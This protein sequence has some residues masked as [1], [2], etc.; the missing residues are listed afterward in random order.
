LPTSPAKTDVLVRLARGED[1]DGWLPLW[2]G[3][4]AFYGREGP[5]ALPD[6]VTADRWATFLAP[7]TAMWSLVACRGDRLVGLANYLFHPS[8]TDLAPSCYLQDLFTASGLR[9]AGVGAAL[10]EGVAERARLAG[11]TNIYWQTHHTNATAMRL[12]D[13]VAARSEFLIYQLPLV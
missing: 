6:S 8:T 13:R 11:S 4:N 10:I 5:T 1:L 2:N 3:Y 7:D 12:Y 9:G